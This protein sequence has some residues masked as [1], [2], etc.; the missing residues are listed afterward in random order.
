MKI[1]TKEKQFGFLF[2]LIFLSIFLY[3]FFFLNRFLIA[4]LLISL[5]L[6]VLIFFVPQFLVIPNRLWIKFGLLLGS[7]TTPIIL[8]F[9]FFV[10]IFP[11]GILKKILNKN[12]LDSKYDNNLQSYWKNCDRKSINFR[13]QF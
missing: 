4:P 2:L 5:I 8:M 12:Y 3:Y 6:L 7:I 11:I 1:F 10:I 9:I 13:K